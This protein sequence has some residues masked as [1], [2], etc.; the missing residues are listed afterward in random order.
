MRRS[1]S[2]RRPRAAACLLQGRDRSGVGCSAGVEEE[3]VGGE[4]VPVERLVGVRRLAGPGEAGAAISSGIP[5]AYRGRS[6]PC[7]FGVACF[8]ESVDKTAAVAF[9]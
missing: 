4:Q 8:E 6:F 9:A 7:A 3:F 2:R 1:G 5:C